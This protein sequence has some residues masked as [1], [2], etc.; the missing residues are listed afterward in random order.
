MPAADQ[1]SLQAEQRGDYKRRVGTLHKQLTVLNISLTAERLGEMDEADLSVRL[2]Y[3]E[4]LNSTFEKAQSSI[5]EIEV[6]EDSEITF[7]FIS[8]FFDVKA[9]LSRQLA[10]KRKQSSLPHSSTV[11]QF[12]LDETTV[13]RKVRLPELKIPQYSG[14]YTEWPGFIS[15]FNTVIDNDSDLSKIEKFQH[16]RVSLI[17]PAL[18]T[19]SSLEPIEANYDKALQL[20]KNRFDN[21]LLN[22]QTHIREIFG[23]KSVDKGSASGLRQLS[24]KLNSH[25]RALQTLCNQEEIADG[26]LVHLITSKICPSTDCPHGPQWHH[27]WNGDAEC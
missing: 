15:M 10:L 22:F 21:K 25:M 19:I 24:D 23:L 6:G 4:G 12:S 11:R 3:L 16:L 9:K 2:D 27:F 14:S 5:A 18:D 20:L 7:N 8:L 13:P 1:C 26:F 17:G